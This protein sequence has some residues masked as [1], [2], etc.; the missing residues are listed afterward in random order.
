MTTISSVQS[1]TP[2]S[3]TSQYIEKNFNAEF[4]CL[5]CGKLLAK[6]NNEQS[7]S[8]QVKCPRCRTLEVM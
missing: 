5:Q 1:A 8:L 6:Y 7:F 4:R 2:S 3:V